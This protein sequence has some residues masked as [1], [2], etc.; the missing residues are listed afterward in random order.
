MSTFR[1]EFASDVPDRFDAYFGLKEGLERLLAR[2]F[3]LVSHAALEN[4]NFVRRIERD[5]LELYA[6]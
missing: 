6:A 4:P 5:G 1:V 2:P 3:N